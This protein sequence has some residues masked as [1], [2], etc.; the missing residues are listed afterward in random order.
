MKSLKLTAIALFASVSV[1]FAQEEKA[2][3]TDTWTLTTLEEREVEDI[4]GDEMTIKQFE[5][6]ES[7]TPV[8]LDPEDRYKLNQ[9]IIYM[10]TIVTKTV[11]LDYDNDD[12]Y[13]AQVVFDYEKSE[14]YDLDFTMTRDGVIIL[15]DKE[16][17][18]VKGMQDNK[19]KMKYSN[20]KT[21]RI[22]ADG[23]YTIMLSNDEN[24]VVKIKDYNRM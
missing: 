6:I 20:V 11:K 13:E 24:I 21:N 1:M 9:D 10:P 18:F 17:I 12:A 2:D 23:E 15:T 8:M 16:D 19:T 22:K 3:L 14:D 5:I 4:D 7:T